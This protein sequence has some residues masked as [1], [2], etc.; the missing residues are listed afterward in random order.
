VLGLLCEKPAHGWSLARALRADGDV[1]RVW[2]TTRPLVYRAISVLGEK[3]YLAEHGSEASSLGPARTLL[4]ATPAGRRALR[5][6]LGRPVEHV[7]DVRSELMLKLLLLERRNDDPRPLLEAQR[8]VLAPRERAL[9]AHARGST[10]FD[11][12]LALWRLSNARAALRFLEVA[13]AEWAPDE[14]P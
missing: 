13:A 5:R 1:G 2:T 14:A 12:T 10:G 9:A 6:W 11:R 8:R 3:G 4:G 7:R